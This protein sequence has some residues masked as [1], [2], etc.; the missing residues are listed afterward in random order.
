MRRY[1]GRH[2]DGNSVRAVDQNVRN[3]DRE[4]LRLFF[5]LI[6]VRN[7]AYHILVEILQIDLLRNLCKTCLRVTHG[8][9]SVSLNGAEVSVTVH[10]HLPLFEILC[11]H[12]EC[13]I[14]GTVAVR[15]ILT[16]G[17]ADNTCGFPVSPVIVGAELHHVVQHPPLH[18][19]QAVADI[20][21]RSGDDDAHRVVDVGFLHQLRIFG[22]DNFFHFKC[23]SPS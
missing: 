16:H 9:C 13:I 20:R 6:E 5:G 10:Q 1:A 3:S 12:D 4:H 11:H 22:S 14:D 7:K 21:Q 19:L 15:M 23:L 2:A 18:R 8:S 17:I